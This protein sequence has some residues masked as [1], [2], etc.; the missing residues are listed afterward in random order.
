MKI[1]FLGPRGTFSY[2]VAKK[3]SKMSEL[4]EYK[5][6]TEVIYGLINKEI[7]EAIVPIE[8]S[9][10]GGVTETIDTLIE[11]D[12]IYVVEE[13]I[14]RVNQNLIANKKYVLNE[15]KEIYSHPQAIAQCRKYIEKNLKNARINQVSSTALAA[16]EIKEKNYC[17]CIANESCIEEYGL[18]LLDKKIQ[19]NNFNDTKFWVLSKNERI[20]GDKISLIFS[21]RNN[22]GALYNVLGIFYENQINLT[23]IESRPAKTRLGEYYFLVDLEINL[24]INKAMKKLNEEC[25]YLKVLGK[26][27]KYKN[28]ESE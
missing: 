24:N 28:N 4:K 27:K 25:D 11:C 1:G 3:Y 9:L 6:I 23:K 5:T 22:P 19:D 2:E 21:T 26:Y 8:N 10:Q 13:I 18:E 14:K 15:I 20:D 16:K 12:G 7:D 17:A